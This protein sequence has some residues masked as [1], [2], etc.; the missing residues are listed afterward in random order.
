MAQLAPHGPE[1]AQLLPMNLSRL[2]LGAAAAIAAVTVAGERRA[3]ACGGCF[4]PPQQ[5]V[6]DVTDERMLLAVSPVQ[7]TLYDQ[8]QYSGSPSNF[9]WV[10]PIKGTVEVGLSADVLF[11]SVAALTQTVINP[12]PVNCPAPNCTAPQNAG[13]G[14]A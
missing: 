2:A 7:T 11:D 3:S 13:L 10:L 12:P 8:I 5:S 14:F 6:S 4:L 9:A 1:G